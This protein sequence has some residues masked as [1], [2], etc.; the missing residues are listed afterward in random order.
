ML[1]SMPDSSRQ[2]PIGLIISTACSVHRRHVA[3]EAEAY[4]RTVSGPRVAAKETAHKMAGILHKNPSQAVF[5]ARF[6]QLISPPVSVG[7]CR[8]V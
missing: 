1:N 4:R 2:V 3:Q 7:I 6:S 8:R 5:S